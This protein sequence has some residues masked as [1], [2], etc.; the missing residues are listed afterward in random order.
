MI[1]F[2]IDNKEIIVRNASKTI[3]SMARFTNFASN[4][5]GLC[6]FLM[7]RKSLFSDN[8]SALL[9]MVGDNKGRASISVPLIMFTG[10]FCGSY[11]NDCLPFSVKEWLYGRREAYDG[12]EGSRGAVLGLRVLA[13]AATSVLAYQQFGSAESA[14]CGVFSKVCELSSPKTASAFSIIAQLSVASWAV[15][16]VAK[17]LS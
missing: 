3:V 15:E 6:G 8:A 7:F 14:I 1:Q 4:T 13:V 10:W 11:I 5:I 2:H 12:W 17:R 16:Y 9:N